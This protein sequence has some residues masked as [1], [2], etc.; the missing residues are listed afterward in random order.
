MQQ[1]NEQDKTIFVVLGM[2]RS[3]TSVITRG[4]NALG[5]PLG[6]AR[7]T[8]SRLEPNRFF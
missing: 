2:P 3:G 1:W 5:V 8:E 6:D 4:L 7:L